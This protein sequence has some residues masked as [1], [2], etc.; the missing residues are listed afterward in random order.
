MKK[1]R[2]ILSILLLIIIFILIS[3]AFLFLR[4]RGSTIILDAKE[5][6]MPNQEIIFFRQDD[7]RWADEALGSSAYT[8]KK[9]GCL[10]C[11]IA[12]ALSMSG[13]EQ[14]PDTLNDQFTFQNVYDSEGNILWEKLRETGNYEADVYNYVT[15]ELLTDI[16]KN[17]N[18][19]IVRVR[20]HGLGNFHYVL[21][22]KA[23]S[24]K[25]YCM[26]PL[27]DGLTPLSKYGNRIYAIR[28]VYPAGKNSFLTTDS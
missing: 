10:I 9:S 18:Y 7:E 23:E 24:G 11:C 12:S 8:L 25:F 21:V 4:L 5:D 15:T 16:L 19:P 28:C 22:V 17:G 13:I 1:N 26:D 20:M 2:P 27:K 6:I 14:T 3:V